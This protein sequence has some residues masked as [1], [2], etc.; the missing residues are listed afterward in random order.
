MQSA[1]PYYPA[2]SG[3]PVARCGTTWRASNT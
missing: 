3:L 2:V 1:L